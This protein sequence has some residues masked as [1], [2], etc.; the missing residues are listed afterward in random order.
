VE[1]DV[2]AGQIEREL[3]AHPKLLFAY[4]DPKP[5]ASASIG[6]VHRARTD[7]GREVIV[8]VQYPGVDDSVDS[9][10]AHLKLALRASG[11][12]NA[13]HR[14]GLNK[15]F[16]EV[17]ARLHEELDYT[18]E[19]ANVRRFRAHHRRHEFVVVPDVVGER[20]AQ[21]VLTL[22]FEPS[23]SISQ[24][25]ELGYDQ[26][27]RNTLAYRLFDAVLSQIY[28]LR[29]VQADPNPANFGFRK[30]GTVV[31]YDF[32]C[33]KDVRRDILQLYREVTISALS[34]DY[35]AVE[36]CLIGL[37]A[38]NLDGPPVSPAYYKTWRDIFLEPFLA[39]QPYDFGH[40]R[41]YERIMGEAKEFILRH[42]QA[43]QPPVELVFVDRAIAGT[44]GNVRAMK[45]IGD[46]TPLLDKY[47]H[48]LPE[49]LQ[50]G[51]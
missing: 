30:D 27:L 25:D 32:G 4:F 19:A 45:A 11:L 13:A 5:F 44:F 18:N 1:F 15:V 20:S 24:L 26:E 49:G 10:L 37:G 46:P 33:V 3:G 21:R 48:T 2:I 28:E 6:Q 12:V 40:T 29:A 39:P 35:D 22:T 8:K 7:D 36:R 43:F 31:L 42:A 14:K 38:R 41:M 34:E 51:A 50:A 16:E 47:I 9:D 17:R 23:D